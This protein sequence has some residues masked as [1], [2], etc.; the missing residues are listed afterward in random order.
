[1]PNIFLYHSD[2]FPFHYWSSGSS[3]SSFD[4]FI[5]I[6]QHSC[7]PHI[8]SLVSS[9]SSFCSRVLLLKND[10]A[11]VSSFFVLTH[12]IKQSPCSSYWKPREFSN[13]RTLCSS[14]PL[15]DAPIRRLSHSQKRRQTA[16]GH[17][18]RRFQWEVRHSGVLHTS[19]CNTKPSKSRSRRITVIPS[20][21]SL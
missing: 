4:L 20:G 19:F 6:Y 5:L 21:H 15:E 3:F 1:M 14:P 10:L 18:A 2:S 16:H 8:P 17:N 12:R 11:I 7:I 9:Y 13:T